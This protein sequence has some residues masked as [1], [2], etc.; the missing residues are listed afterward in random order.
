MIGTVQPSN[1]EKIWCEIRVDGEF[2]NTTDPRWIETD[3]PRD[4]NYIWQFPTLQ[5]GTRVSFDKKPGTGL[6]L[7]GGTF[8]TAAV[9]INVAAL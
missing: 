7:P 1:F 4:G 3:P 2:P 9:A 5:A 6:V 8:T